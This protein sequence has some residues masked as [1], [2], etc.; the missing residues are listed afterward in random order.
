[1]PWPPEPRH[2]YTEEE[3]GSESLH[4]QLQEAETDWNQASAI[5]VEGERGQ[6][7]PAAECPGLILAT[8][9]WMEH[10]PDF[11]MTESDLVPGVLMPETTY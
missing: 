5:M 9:T 4:T 6:A 1:M 7:R 2:R 11:F 10:L 3:G 8:G